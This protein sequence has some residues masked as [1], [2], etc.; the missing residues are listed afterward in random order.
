MG[1][2]DLK[3][4]ADEKHL[5]LRGKSLSIGQIR[6]WTLLITGLTAFA[7]VVERIAI[8]V[9]VVGHGCLP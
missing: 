2:K 5:L 6:E 9:G 1:D 7:V 3:L 8:G 4:P